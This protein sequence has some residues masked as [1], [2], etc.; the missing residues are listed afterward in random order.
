MEEGSTKVQKKLVKKW[1]KRKHN[2]LL[3]TKMAL[4]EHQILNK[5]WG[6]SNKDV[7]EVQNSQ[8]PRKKPKQSLK[9]LLEKSVIP[10]FRPKNHQIMTPTD[11]HYDPNFDIKSLHFI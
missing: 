9:S 3:D 6:A 10:Y 1:N 5:V 2:E 4:Q 11:P 7:I 8:I